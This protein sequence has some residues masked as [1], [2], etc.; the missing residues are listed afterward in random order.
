MLGHINQYQ[1]QNYAPIRDRNS[2]SGRSTRR[3]PGRPPD[4]LTIN[5]ACGFDHIGHWYG[6]STSPYPGFQVL[7]PVQLSSTAPMRPPIP[8]C[9]GTATDSAF[10][11]PALCRRSSTSRLVSALPLI[12]SA[13]ARPSSAAASALTV[14]SATNE[15]AT[16]WQWSR[17]VR[18]SYTTPTRPFC[19]RR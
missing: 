5:S 18:S 2:I 9:C 17:R 14:T 15:T 10:P 6:L 19:I 1:Q 12:S 13:T 11:S 7:G 4:P 3:T 16:R 8:G